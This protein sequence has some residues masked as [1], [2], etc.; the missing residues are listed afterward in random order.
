MKRVAQYDSATG[1]LLTVFPSITA[2]AESIYGANPA[3]ICACCKGRLKTAYGYVWRYH[4][5]KGDKHD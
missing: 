5:A 4:R 3:H 1:E 2:A